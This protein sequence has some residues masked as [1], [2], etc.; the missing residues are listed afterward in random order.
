MGIPMVMPVGTA[1]VKVILLI[2]AGSAGVNVTLNPK[3]GH[4]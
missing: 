2:L 4:M 1:I 3:N